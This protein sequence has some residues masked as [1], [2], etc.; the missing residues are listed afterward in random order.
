MSDIGKL[1]LVFG[2][3]IAG[4]GL[5]LMLAGRIPGVG[6]LPGDIYIQR[7]NFSFYFP[8]VT[9]LLVSVLLTLLFWFF[10]RR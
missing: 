1:L 4:V 6:R 9:S 3:L 8:V 2:L 7:G 10:S 5:V